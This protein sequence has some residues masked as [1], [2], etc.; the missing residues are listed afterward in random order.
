MKVQPG[1]SRVLILEENGYR[2]QLD[3]SNRLMK[4][5][6]QDTESSVLSLV[7]TASVDET[8]TYVCALCWG[9]LPASGDERSSLW[10]SGKYSTY[11][12]SGMRC[13]ILSFHVRQPPTQQIVCTNQKLSFD[14]MTITFTAVHWKYVWIMAFVPS[15]VIFL[16]SLMIYKEKLRKI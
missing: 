10:S 7:C 6:C 15:F 16:V 8:S 12:I 14:H 5:S 1:V 9:V 4:W 3:Y 2:M 13:S 11:L